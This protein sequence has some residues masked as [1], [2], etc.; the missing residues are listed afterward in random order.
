MGNINSILTAILCSTAPLT[1]AEIP[2]SKIEVVQSNTL[3]VETISI[4]RGDYEKGEYSEFLNDM[5]QDYLEAMTEG[6][7]QGLIEMRQR[8]VS[9]DL[10]D[11]W[12]QKFSSLQNERNLAL[13]GAISDTDDSVFAK[14]VRSLAANLSTPE[15]EKAIV[16]L[17]SLLNKAPGTGINEDE[18]T[19]IDIDLE[20]EYKILH[21]Q[22][23]SSE[24]SPQEQFK[25]QIVLRMD[26]MAKMVEASKNFKDHSLKQIVGLS[27]ANLDARLARNLDGSE[28]NSAVKK[29]VKPTSETEE[30]VYS[31]ISL[32]QGQFSDLMKDLTSNP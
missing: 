2:D 28:L 11:Q 7:L 19:L 22:L 31:I 9:V 29:H 1:A 23:P 27:S 12:E 30:N 20:Y 5:D 17:N 16:K 3:G 18:N 4:L 25:Q 8:D 21:G 26:K 32:Y 15:Q 24:V 6:D 14:K 10:Q 13:L